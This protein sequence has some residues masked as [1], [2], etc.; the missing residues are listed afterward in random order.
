[1][2]FR[3]FLVTFW[4]FTKLFNSFLLVPLLPNQVLRFQA[5]SEAREYWNRLKSLNVCPNG[6]SN[7]V[8]EWLGNRG[9]VEIGLIEDKVLNLFGKKLPV[10]LQNPKGEHSRHN[11]LV[12]LEETS[13]SEMES[14][15]RN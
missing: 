9:W 12:L 11:N 3:Y 7:E 2:E 5:G 13:T 6:V 1:M 10:S 14:H 8:F 15:H 4:Q